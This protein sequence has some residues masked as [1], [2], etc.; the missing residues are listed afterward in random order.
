MYIPRVSSAIL[1][2]LASVVDVRSWRF[3]CCVVLVFTLNSTEVRCHARS[4]VYISMGILQSEK[5]GAAGHKRSSLAG[6]AGPGHEPEPA[7]I[8]GPG[9]RRDPG[10]RH[11]WT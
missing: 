11:T 2:T 4:N 9:C 5:G 10:E 3:R 8:P 6:A 1:A 7:D